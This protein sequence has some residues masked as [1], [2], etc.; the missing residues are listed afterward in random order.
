ML[1]KLS[2]YLSHKFHSLISNNEL[3]VKSDKFAY[4]DVILTEL[5]IN[6][7]TDLFLVRG[8]FLCSGVKKNDSRNAFFQVLWNSVVVA[9]PLTPEIDNTYNNNQ[10]SMYNCIIELINYYLLEFDITIMNKSKARHYE[11]RKIANNVVHE[12]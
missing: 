4:N 6:R 10:Y 8:T 1:W 3:S 5:D 9:F 2:R 11:T 12:S 7:S